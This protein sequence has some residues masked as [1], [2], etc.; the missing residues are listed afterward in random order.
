MSWQK[1]PK[2][3][4]L[5]PD[6]LWSKPENK[7][8]AGKLLVIGGSAGSFKVVSSAYQFADKAGAGSIRLLMPDAI[9]PYFSRLQEPSLQTME[10]APSNK[11]GGFAKSALAEFLELS[12]WAN[13]VLLAGDFGKNS[14]T[15]ILLETYLKKSKAPLTISADTIKSLDVKQALKSVRPDT[16]LGLEFGQLQQLGV[17]LGLKQAITSTMP[18]EKLASVLSEITAFDSLNIAGYFNGLLWA[19]S[20]SKAVSTPS[21]PVDYA[22]LA[23]YVAVWCMQNP[24]KK[25]EAMATAIYEYG[26]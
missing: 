18:A 2:D 23:S 7:S 22:K 10:F 26:R 6:L 25:I 20:N 9:R 14:E 8:Q 1:Q 5:Y 21:K 13:H 19:A 11:S 4:P 24:S 17:Q 12:Q 16:F 15:T 3:K